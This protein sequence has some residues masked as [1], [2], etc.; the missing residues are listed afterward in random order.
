LCSAGLHPLFAYGKPARCGSCNRERALERTSETLV[1][2][3]PAVSPAGARAALERAAPTTKM[4]GKV[5]AHLTTHPTALTDGDSAAPLP[6]ARLIDALRAA[7]VHGLVDPCCMDCGQAKHLHYRVPGGRVCNACE[8]RRRPREPCPRC[9]KLSPR[10]ARV[11]GV[12]VGACCYV[13][14]AERCTV[15]GVNRSGRSYRTRRRICTDCAQRSH[16]SCETCGRDAPI[17][18]TG[19]PARCVPCATRSP[20]PCV[21][22]G[23]LTV[24]LDRSRRPRCEKCYRRPTRMCGRCG[25][26][27][28]IVRKAV[29]GEPDLC[30]ICW[31]GPTM[32]CERCGQERPC[33]GERRGR[34]LCGGCAPVRP[35]RCGHCGR[36]RRPMAHWPEGPVCNTCYHRALS[37]KSVCP[38]CGQT[39]RLLRYPGFAEPVC[40]HCAGAD[41]DHVCARCGAEEALHKRGVCARCV[42]DDRLTEL[43]GDPAHRARRGLNGLFDAL[44]AAR[45]AK[46]MLRWLADSPAT[47]IIAQIAGGEAA[48]SHETLDRLADGPAVRR[49]EHLLVATGALPPRDPALARLERWIAEFLAARDDEAPLRSYARW[50]VL[51]RYRR[52]S[53]R[54]PLT[55]GGL[56]RPKAELRSA[57]AFVDWLTERQTPLADCKQS[58]IDAWLAGPRADRHIARAFVRWAI[59]R[60]LTPKLDFPTGSRSGPTPPVTD[61]DRVALARQL[62]HDPSIAVRDRVAG[63]LIVLF[64]QPV[65]RIA[66]LI[67]DDI[68]VVDESV[69]VRFGD[70][71]ITLPEPLAS[72]LRVLIADRRGCVAAAV[73]ESRWLFP[74]GSPG[75]PISERV[76]SL[77]LKRIGVDCPEARRTALL[78][79]AGQM[80]AALVADLLGVHVATATQWAQIAGRTWSDY[81]AL[82]AQ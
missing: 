35:Q 56:S 57:R 79:L 30:A 28:V 11:D 15:C 29:D 52:K 60:G 18:E 48:C 27:R 37:A 34:W 21:V 43:L 71:A 8:K 14:P 69:A 54:A 51:H 59:A 45:S 40:R 58:D 22:C 50:V 31:T 55:T 6:V 9:G 77:R 16:T 26:V 81:P 1:T 19:A 66:R 67:V 73:P 23:E 82:R 24:A 49:L 10:G 38:A 25:R 61:H 41:D 2:C 4:L 72:D 78:Q 46:D 64:A 44:Y 63:V 68:T 65:G 47:A 17:P 42:L 39:R 70:T 76:L 13:R 7:G 32:A 74:G 3:F 80:P 53:R 12:M 5:A 62:L 20:A 75:Q 33:R 36:D